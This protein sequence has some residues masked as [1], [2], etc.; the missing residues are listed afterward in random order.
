MKKLLSFIICAF[1][2]YTSFAQG[3]PR[4]NTYWDWETRI[5]APD[6]SMGITEKSSLSLNTIDTGCQIFI[7]NNIL[8]YYSHGT[9][10]SVAGG[11]VIDT[12]SMSNRIEERLYIDDTDNAFKGRFLEFITAQN[13]DSALGYVP[14]PNTRIL[15]I[16]GISKNLQ[17]DPI[18]TLSFAPEVF[19][20][21]PGT[22]SYIGQSGKLIEKIEI[23]EPTSVSIDI[24]T[25]AGAHDIS[26]GIPVNTGYTNFS[27]DYYISSGRT[28]YFTGATINTIFKIYFR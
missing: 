4:K 27:F 5:K 10:Y 3:P 18:F 22:Y 21:I 23:I 15:T 16:N 7:Y 2:F 1:S 8:Y 24:G 12:T 17:T 6:S 19:T 26:Q 9:Y 13:V 20:V 11:N 25:T 28:L 14:V